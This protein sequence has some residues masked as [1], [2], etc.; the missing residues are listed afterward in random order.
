MSLASEQCRNRN[1]A[2]C[3]YQS[4]D[5]RSLCHWWRNP[6]CAPVADPAHETALSAHGPPA[7]GPQVEVNN[8]TERCQA[9]SDFCVITNL[10]RKPRQDVWPNMGGTTNAV[11]A[12]RT[13][14]EHDRQGERIST[15]VVESTV[16]Q[17]VRTQLV[18]QPPRAGRQRGAPLLRQTRTGVNRG[19]GSSVLS[20]ISHFAI[21]SGPEGGMPCGTVT[22]APGVARG[23]GWFRRH[24][25][26][27]TESGA[28]RTSRQEGTGR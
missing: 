14:I 10:E 19:V 6:P 1:T 27:P 24:T 13:S 15:G 8:G 11:E 20:V 5:L 21:T 23:G 4:S 22:V 7:R 2:T 17:E 9:C 16:H 12:C 25:E 18:K 3:R 26:W 28:P